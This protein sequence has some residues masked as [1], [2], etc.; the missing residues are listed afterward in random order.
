MKG[1]AVLVDLRRVARD[2]WLDP[3][4]DIVEAFA[5]R[6]MGEDVATV[7]VGGKVVVEDRRSLT[8]DVEALYREIRAFCERGLSPEHRARAD[9]L[10]ELKPHVQRWYAGWHDGMAEAPF[11]RVNSRA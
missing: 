8:I 11:Y 6:A 7:V 5:E 3:Q 1:D 2:P 10:R 4:F 9:L